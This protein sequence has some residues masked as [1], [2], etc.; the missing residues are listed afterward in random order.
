MTKSELINA[1]EKQVNLP[2]HFAEK[3]VNSVFQSMIESLLK[4]ER[5]EIRGFGSFHNRNY[6]A[7]QG[8]NPK[9]GEPLKVEAKKVPF[10]K[11]GNELKQVIN[12][13]DS[14]E[15]QEITE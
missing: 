14:S 6:K 7:Y 1:L 15:E 13:D 3:A 9:S 10:F 8:R 11:A 2:H 12:E 5:I 4:D